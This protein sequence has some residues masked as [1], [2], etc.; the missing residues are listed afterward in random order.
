M[1]ATENKSI[2]DFL[3]G[4]GEMGELIRNYDWSNSSI[5]TPDR[6]S[7][8]LLTTLSIILH[9]RFPMFLFWGTN[10]LCFYNDSYRPSLGVNAKHPRILGMP[11]KEAW[12]EIWDFIGP[13][14]RDILSG[15]DA[16]WYENQPLPLFRNGA[17]ENVFWT[18]SYSVV[19]DESGCPAGV[20]VTCVETTREVKYEQQLRDSADKLQFA[21]D[22]AELATWDL[23]PG[24]GRLISNERLQSWFGIEPGEEI[25]LSVPLD[26]IIPGDRERVVEAL[27][28]AANYESGGK[29]NEQYTIIHP[30][31]HQKRIIRAKGLARFNENQEAVLLNGT[32]QDVTEQATIEKVLKDM[33]ARLELVSNTVPA[34]IFYLD[35]Q[36]RYVS[37]NDAYMNWFGINARELIGK[38]AKEFL[39]DEFYKKIA[40][41]LN[42]AYLGEQVRYE[43]NVPHHSGSTKKWLSVVYT[44][45]VDDGVVQGVIVHATDITSNKEVEFA[46]RDSEARF[47]ALI[48]EAPVATCLY[49]GRDMKIEV[50]NSSM[51]EYMGRD[52]SIIGKPLA[53]ALPE[54]IGQPFL[55][56]LNQAF[57]TGETIQTSSSPVEVEHEGKL[58]TY[59]FDITLKPVRNSDGEVYGILDMAID[60][61]KHVLAKKDLEES[62]RALRSFILQAPIAIA[63]LRSKKY[64]VEVVNKHA[65]EFWGRTSEEVTDLP[66]FEALPELQTQGFR[67]F[68]D[69]IYDSGIPVSL[70][71]HPIEFYRNGKKD[72]FYFNFLY[73]V[74]HGADGKVNG[75][76]AVGVDQTLQAKSRMKIEEA[77]TDRTKAL[78]EANLLL[79]QTNQ[80]LEQFVYI[81]SHDLQEPLRKLRT[82]AEMLKLNTVESDET[83]RGYLDKIA[84]SSARMTQL[85]RD[86]LEFSELSGVNQ[87]ITEVDLNETIEEVISDLEL[88]IDQ[89]K[90][91]FNVQKLPVLIANDRQMKQLF[92]NLLSNALKFSRQNIRPLITIT[93]DTLPENEKIERSS[94]QPLKDYYKITISDN[95][96]GFADEH[97]Q[98]IFE[99]FRRLHGKSRYEGTGIGLAL[100]K[101]IVSNYQGDIWANSVEGKG[102]NFFVALPCAL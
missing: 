57:L 83:S 36:Q 93:A 29:Y 65:L 21:I 6:W 74:L 99:I 42:R 3:R 9:S 73:E 101:K 76:M 1:L 16:T 14:I 52:S 64:V 47:R 54:L 87:F 71:E 41:Y 82:Y 66:L 33:N 59:Y 55:E 23:E 8:S 88:V 25:N 32:L 12:P 22:A 45:H 102:S 81:A 44:P 38:T 50:I 39:G 49:V 95:G 86:I 91:T 27:N 62:E 43:V 11:A 97:A 2:I 56:S 79:K 46:L 19:C 85:I 63:I 10:H 96:I 13:M 77:V 67:E 48:E 92:G 15:G 89:K 84:S 5:G 90:A 75:L 30:V 40:P 28:R 4:G 26:A 24:T 70:T 20:F 35:H 94:L 100:C 37:Y 69:N 7:P 53:H 80:E 98:K 78:A 60:V 58:N 18:F 72:L 68:F 51:L 61:T 31:T 34:L 17:M